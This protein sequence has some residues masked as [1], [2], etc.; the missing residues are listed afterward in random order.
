MHLTTLVSLLAVGAAAAPAKSWDLNTT[1]SKVARPS[2]TGILGGLPEAPEVTNLVRRQEEGEEETPVDSSSSETSSS[3]AGLLPELP[4][5]PVRRRQEPEPTEEPSFRSFVAKQDSE[6]AAEAKKDPLDA[7]LDTLNGDYDEEK[8][9]SALD[10]YNDSLE[11]DQST[12]TTSTS[13]AAKTPVPETVD[14]TVPVDTKNVTSTET[15]GDVPAE[16]DV[17]KL[18]AKAEA[19]K[20]ETSVEP[21][22][23]KNAT[24]SAVSE[25]TKKAASKDPLARLSGA[26]PVKRQEIPELPQ[27]PAVQKRQLGD[28]MGSVPE[29][30]EEDVATP[31]VSEKNVTTPA[32]PAVGE[33][34]VAATTTDAHNATSSAVDDTA[35]KASSTAA[36]GYQGINKHM[37]KL[38]K[39][40]VGG[41]PVKR[42][43]P[44]KINN[45]EVKAPEVKPEDI[46]TPTTGEQHID[47]HPMS[48]EGATART[49]RPSAAGRAGYKNMSKLDW[50]A[51][52]VKRQIEDAAEAV[53]K[54]DEEDLTAPEVKPE[55]LTAPT[56]PTV[57]EKQIDS[58]TPAVNETTSV[59][60]DTSADASST[61]AAG[62][63]NVNK[64]VSQLDKLP[65]GGLP[66]KRQAPDFL[67][68]PVDA[69][70][71]AS[72]QPTGG[73]PD[74]LETP[75]DAPEVANP[76][77]TGG[78]PTES[79]HDTPFAGYTSTEA[80]SALYKYLVPLQ[81]HNEV[82]ASEVT[83][84]AP[85]EL[86][87]E[88]PSVA[89]VEKR[90]SISKTT[91]EVTPDTDAVE[92]PE[93]AAP[94]AGLDGL[95]GG[96]A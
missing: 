7:Y 17:E 81:R 93:V 12:V 54:V 13:V 95:L 44:T 19:P 24:S 50:L 55:E 42:Q 59:V 52:P 23:E 34:D 36:A 41:L 18:M 76:Q 47:S 35:A 88:V 4:T 8:S 96:L 78:L 61:A 28:L 45:E 72:P 69:P 48:F 1:L 3:S 5:L 66:V 82:A 60:D 30:K 25:P 10:H 33:E 31:D 37:S 57:G 22:A 15:V 73:L 21:A 38:D 80:H 32:V 83:A 2:P 53:P 27:I 63:H 39:L 9:D 46:R 70:E 16:F 87:E 77:P 43:I 79:V 74:W 94:D 67:T 26:L 92:T 20:N 68:A 6:A 29:V 64:H 51:L 58:K 85:S 40:P 49:S 75:A 14:S 65:L 11:K 84:A 90:D 62:Y 86:P 56:T 91:E 89:P 71:V